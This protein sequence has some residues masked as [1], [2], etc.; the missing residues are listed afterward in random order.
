MRPL[1][2]GVKIPP[3]VVRTHQDLPPLSNVKILFEASKLFVVKLW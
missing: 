2:L 3:Y 1:N